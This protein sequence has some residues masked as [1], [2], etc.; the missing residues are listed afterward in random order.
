MSLKRISKN[1]LFAVK[2]THS[3]LA[4]ANIDNS[5]IQAQKMILSLSKHDLS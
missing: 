4:H 5:Y 3:N 1:S 2:M